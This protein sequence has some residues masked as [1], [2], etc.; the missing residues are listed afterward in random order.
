[1][2]L[3]RPM[4]VMAAMLCTCW[5]TLGGGSWALLGT[6]LAA[7]AAAHAKLR[8]LSPD[9]DAEM[10]GLHLMGVQAV[11]MH[12]RLGPSPVTM[13]ALAVWLLSYHAAVRRF[14]LHAGALIALHDAGW[15]AQFPAL[16]CM[17]QQLLADAPCILDLEQECGRGVLG[18]CCDVPNAWSLNICACII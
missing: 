16:S 7:A 1:M 18:R 6:A 5:Y 10:M 8:S 14:V 4:W 11:Q 12:L 9:S 17:Q 2:R 15:D 3:H 13:L